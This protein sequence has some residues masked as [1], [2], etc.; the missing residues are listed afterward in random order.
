MEVKTSLMT[1]IGIPAAAIATSL[2]LGTYLVKND[3]LGR[4]S[5]DVY[6]ARS[7][8]DFGG[9]VRHIPNG[10]LQPLR[11]RGTVVE[12]ETRVGE[13]YQTGV[14]VYRS[15]DMGIDIENFDP[16]QIEHLESQRYELCHRAIVEE[17]RR[18]NL[19]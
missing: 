9:Y 12:N 8:D 1:K 19:P 11:G 16:S 15:C 2:G 7:L 5:N 13:S 14:T 10:E 18:R 17:G 4:I 6:N 3:P